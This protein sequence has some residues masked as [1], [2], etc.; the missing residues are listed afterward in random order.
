MSLTQPPIVKEEDERPAGKGSGH[1]FY[2]P[3]KIGERHAEDCVI[4]E[5]QV[6]VRATIEYTIT[7]PHSWKKE[8]IEFHRNEGSWCSNNMI[9]E[10]EALSE[11]NCLCPYTEFMYLRD[12]EA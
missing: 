11:H 9:P 5:K 10:L 4:W 12:G 7:V 1:C 3:S 8:D 2:C 6:V